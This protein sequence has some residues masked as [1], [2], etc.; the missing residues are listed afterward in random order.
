MLP[1]VTGN[2]AEASAKVSREAAC[3]GGAQEGKVPGHRAQRDPGAKLLGATPG[4]LPPAT[5]MWVT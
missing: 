2:T 5:I 4:I 1:S 3:T